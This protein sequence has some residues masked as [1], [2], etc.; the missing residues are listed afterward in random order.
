MLIAC[1]VF[2]LAWWLVAFHPTRAIHGL[3]SGWLL[4]PAFIFAVLSIW[5]ISHGISAV[6]AE[7][8]LV[9]NI[10]VITAGV[11]SYIVLLVL[12]ALIFKRMVTSELIIITA[13]AFFTFAELSAFY[14]LGLF[15]RPAAT[16]F[17]AATFIAAA[18]SLV[19][20][21]LYYNLDEVKGYIDGMIPLLMAGLMM[22]AITVKAGM[23]I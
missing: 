2:Y 17:I 19:C 7:T 11:V 21:V 6:K 23:S 20:Y 14:G 15:T 22:T 5:W 12:T 16:G 3:K 9:P 10:V 8:L 4:I 1:C 18:V 13:W